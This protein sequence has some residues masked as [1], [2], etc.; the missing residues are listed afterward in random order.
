[1][2]DS[3]HTETKSKNKT[4]W[5]IGGVAILAL[6]TAAIYL[7]DVDLT[8][9]AELPEVQV[10]GG[11]MPAVDVDVA[12]IDV[13][14]KEVSVEVPTIDI[15]PP[16]EGQEADD[17]ADNIDVDVDADVDFDADVEMDPEQN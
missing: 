3:Y 11:Q 12:D 2:T 1:M 8:Q 4:G 7:T 5:I 16:K 6:G 9:T 17:L 10:E 14:S 13:G 15:D